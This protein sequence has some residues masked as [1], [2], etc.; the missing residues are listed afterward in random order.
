MAVKIGQSY[1]SEAA[2]NFAKN[3]ADNGENVLK[4]LQEK[5][6]NLKI[7]VG[8]APFAGSG[9]NNLSISP[10]ILNEMQKN[11]D[12]K[13]EYEALIYDIANQNVSQPG[14]KSHGFIIDDK[15]GLRGWGISEHNDRKN[16][17]LN[18]KNKNSWLDSLLPQKKTKKTSMMKNIFATKSKVDIL[19]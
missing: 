5:F 15:G 10:K 19:A 1:V 11:P 14:L 6:P 16:T 2:V 17:P 4:S 7:S 3:S 8:T 9:T 12:K 13:V 18:K